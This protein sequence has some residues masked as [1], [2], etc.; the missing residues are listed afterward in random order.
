MYDNAP[1]IVCVIDRSGSMQP[2]QADAIGGFNTFL[3]EQQRLTGDARLTLV[4]FDHEYQVVHDG[5]GVGEARPLDRSTYVPRGQTALLDAIGRAIMTVDA[6]LRPTNSTPVIVCILTDGEENA[7][8]EYRQEQVSELIR[9]H[10]AE[11]GW[12]FVFLSAREDAF[13]TAASLSIDPKHSASFASSSAGIAGAY[14]SV[15]TM[16]KS[17]RSGS[18]DPSSG[19]TGNS[20]GIFH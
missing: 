7:S 2:L 13:K 6:R 15:T 19:R 4:L 18:E 20:G 8:V 12:Q 14:K 11:Q 3:A 9:R 1:E 10:R 16:V 5:I 17:F